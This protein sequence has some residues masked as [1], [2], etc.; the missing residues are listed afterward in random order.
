MYSMNKALRR[1]FK[2]ARVLMGGIRD[3][4]DI[5]LMDV[6]FHSKENDG[7]RYLLIVIDVFTRYLWAGPLYN[8]TS[9][10]VLTALKTCFETIGTPKKVRSDLGKEFTSHK[11]QAYLKSIGVKHFTTQGEA[12]SNYVKRVIKTLRSLIHRYT[13]KLRYFRYIDTLNT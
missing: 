11:T 4:Y 12:K 8:R 7:V 9:A 6:S 13:K 10:A 5:D 3:Q 2:R 1:R